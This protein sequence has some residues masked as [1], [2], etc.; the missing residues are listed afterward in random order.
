MKKKNK[1]KNKNQISLN[2]VLNS[3]AQRLRKE[4]CIP[5]TCLGLAEM[6]HC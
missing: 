5:I 1:N 4:N 3:N 6:Q 2:G